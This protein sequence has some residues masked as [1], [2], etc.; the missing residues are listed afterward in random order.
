MGPTHF[1]TVAALLFGIGAAGAIWRRNALMV[2]MSIELMLNAANIVFVAYG[3]QYGDNG[4]HAIAFFVM[5]IAAAEAAVGLAILI[6][7]FRTRQTIEVDE[8]DALR[9]ET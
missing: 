6:G 5:A 4:S 8:L 3:R 1:I 7:I 9:D 2:L